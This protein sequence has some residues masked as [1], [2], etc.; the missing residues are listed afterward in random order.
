MATRY[1]YCNYNTFKKI[2][3][4]KTLRLS[5]IRKSNDSYEMILFL[6]Q[7]EGTGSLSD[8]FNDGGFWRNIE[9]KMMKIT[10]DTECFASCL[11]IGSDRL[12]QWE[13]YGDKC[14]GLAIGFN[15]EKL[16]SYI[17]LVAD[18]LSNSN[19]SADFSYLPKLVAKKI[20]YKKL[21]SSSCPSVM[22]DK[23]KD[24]K[25]YFVEC[26]F[27][28]DKG[29]SEEKEFRI[30]LMFS[31]EELDF[32]DDNFKEYIGENGFNNLYERKYIDLKIPANT[33]EAV[34]IGP[35]NDISIDMIKKELKTNEVYCKVKKSTIPYNPSRQKQ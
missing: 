35:L 26:A 17:A 11:S 3:E 13:R 20:T 21:L 7:H 24:M 22:V 8:Y 16:Q 6:K 25:K 30:A 9:K 14:K 15:E 31:K 10:N 29:F 2:I 32:L 23:F 5:D 4:K 18:S 1:H 33:I 19:K 34:Y 27:T 28:K 12:S